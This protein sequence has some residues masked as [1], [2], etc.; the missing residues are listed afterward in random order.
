[1][2]TGTTLSLDGASLRLD[3]LARVLRDPATRVELAPAARERVRASRGVVERA[4]ASGATIYGIT[5]G[6]GRLAE[7]RIGPE[8][9][10]A[11]QRNLV[12]SHCAG[13]GDA[14]PA[15]E[16]RLLLLLRANALAKGLSGVREGTLDALVALL[17][18]GV[19]PVVPEK[20]SVGASGDL[21]PLA[22]LAAVLIGEGRASV[23]GVEMPGAA[24]L[25]RAGLRPVVLE[26][27]EG[28]SLI[29]GTQLIC[30]LGA[31]ATL[32]A[33]ALV[34]RADIV[35]ALSLDALHGTD[36]AF[37]ERIH[38]ARPHAGQGA[39]ARNLRRLL[40]GSAIRESHRG[41]SCKKVQDAY[42]LRCAPQVHGAARDALAYVERALETELNAATDN[43]L[44]FPDPNDPGAGGAVLSGGNF[45][46]APVAL[47]MDVLSIAGA[48]V[49]A[50]S[51]RRIERLV[52][53]DYSGLPAFLSRAAPGL[54]SGLMIAQVTAAALVSENKALAHPASVDS[55]P[56]SAG[57]ED[58]VSMGPHAARKARE[59]VRNA[60]TVAAIELIAAAQAVEMS[61]PLRTSPPLEAARAALR[62]RVPPLVEDRPL[63]AD[64]AAALAL[65]REHEVIRRVEAALG[66]ALE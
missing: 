10:R 65:I 20:G 54:H 18:A 27:K 2:A 49:A 61:A 57:F 53:P 25:E 50:I 17:N 63:A 62:E 19:L 59:V 47:A 34:R 28:L 37:D 11:L 64:I 56:T 26:A 3:D 40:A 1:M 46:G 32:G 23:G 60:E 39:S 36:V 66:G 5:T 12:L 21:A 13:V 35:A 7:K 14:L 42:S 31:V 16:T 55:I 52:N 30:A 38:A 58:H 48:Q 4:L 6:F 24:A 51:E 8:E 44:V 9:T 33:R 43:P 22:H 41:P 29:N 15:A 45:H